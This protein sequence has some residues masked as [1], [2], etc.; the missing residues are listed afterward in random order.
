MRISRLALSMYRSVLLKS[1]P[2]GVIVNADRISEKA[3][4]MI[5]LSMLKS[6]VSGLRGEICPAFTCIV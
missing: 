1:A 6:I 3:I 5:Q 2:N 4:E